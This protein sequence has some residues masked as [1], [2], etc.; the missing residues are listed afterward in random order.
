[1][2]LTIEEA[3]AVN[4]LIREVLGERPADVGPARV[5]EAMC[6][7]ADH[8]FKPLMAGATSS[9]VMASSWAQENLR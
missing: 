8:A 7:L 4:V 6:L 3:T 9:S 5:A 2:A 1:M